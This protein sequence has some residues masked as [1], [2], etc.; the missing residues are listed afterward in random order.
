[1]GS[2]HLIAGLVSGTA[3]FWS[4]EG[5]AIRLPS[6]TF[7]CTVPSGNGAGAT[8]RVQL[9]P[10]ESGVL[11]QLSGGTG[12]L[13]KFVE[14]DLGKLM[15]GQNPAPPLVPPITPDKRVAVFMMSHDIQVGDDKLVYRDLVI[16]NG[17]DEYFKSLSPVLTINGVEV[18][19]SCKVARDQSGSKVLK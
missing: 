13:S 17:D 11:A 19:S 8:F 4:A 7:A 12:F 16:A 10:T 6:A 2:R 18:Q 14:I 9:Q 5:H 1:M 15:V 3:I